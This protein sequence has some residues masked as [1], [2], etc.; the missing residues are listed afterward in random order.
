MTA[1][2]LSAV[3]LPETEVGAVFGIGRQDLYVR[4]SIGDCVSKTS[5]LRNAGK[6]GVWDAGEIFT[7]HARTSWLQDGP[8]R[9]DLVLK[10]MNSNF[11]LPDTLVGEGRVCILEHWSTDD[12]PHVLSLSLSRPG[13]GEYGT[14][15]LGITLKSKRANRCQLQVAEAARQER[16]VILSALKRSVK[17]ATLSWQQA[18]RAVESGTDPA[19]R[20]DLRYNAARC[21]REVNRTKNRLLAAKALSMTAYVERVQRRMDRSELLRNMQARREAED[22]AAIAA[23]DDATANAVALRTLSYLRNLREYCH[24]KVTIEIDPQA[25][26]GIVWGDVDSEELNSLANGQS[27]FESDASEIGKANKAIFPTMRGPSA[28]RSDITTLTDQHRDDLPRGK[29]ALELKLKSV[30]SELAAISGHS[31]MRSRLAAAEAGPDLRVTAVLP[32]SQSAAQGVRVG[33]RAV[34]LDDVV[35]KARHQLE[36]EILR[37]K[38]RLENGA[39]TERSFMHLSFT[40]RVTFRTERHRLRTLRQRILCEQKERA[41]SDFAKSMRKKRIT[42]KLG[43]KPLG[44]TWTQATLSP[45]DSAPSDVLEV[46]HSRIFLYVSPQVVNVDPNSTASM[47]KVRGGWILTHLGGV[48][49]SKE[50][51]F[52]ETLSNLRATSANQVDIDFLAPRGVDKR[53]IM[54]DAQE[55]FGVTKWSN[56]N[57]VLEIA[58]GS[59]AARLR[60]CIGWVLLSLNGEQMN[61]ASKSAAPSALAALRREAK[62]RRGIPNKCPAVFNA[63]SDEIKHV[64]LDQ[65]QTLLGIKWRVVQEDD[66][67]GALLVV[68]DAADAIVAR[69]GWK[70]LKARSEISDLIPRTSAALNSFVNAARKKGNVVELIFD[71]FD[72]DPDLKEAGRRE[73]QVTRIDTMINPTDLPFLP[74]VEP[75]LY[76]HIVR[77]VDL[78]SF[79]RPPFVRIF[80]CGKEIGRSRSG[81]LD[82]AGQPHWKRGTESFLLPMPAENNSS[83]QKSES[84]VEKELS[85]NNVGDN[86]DIELL[87]EIWTARSTPFA[88]FC[89][90]QVLLEGSDLIRQCYRTKDDVRVKRPVAFKLMPKKKRNHDEKGSSA[91]SKLFIS[92]APQNKSEGSLKLMLYLLHPHDSQLGRPPLASR[93][94][95]DQEF[96]QETLSMATATLT[97]GSVEEEVSSILLRIDRSPT[98]CRDALVRLATLAVSGQE[99]VAPVFVARGAAPLLVRLLSHTKSTADRLDAATACRGLMQHGSVA[100]RNALIAAGVV[101]PLLRLALCKDTSLFDAAAEALAALALAIDTGNSSKEDQLLLASSE[102]LANE[103][104]GINTETL[105]ANYASLKQFLESPEE[106]DASESNR[107][108]V[109]EILRANYWTDFVQLIRHGSNRVKADSARILASIAGTTFG[110]EKLEEEAKSSVDKVHTKAGEEVI[111]ALLNVADS[112]VKNA[113]GVKTDCLRSLCRLLLRPDI[114]GYADRRNKIE[115]AEARRIIGELIFHFSSVIA[116]VQEA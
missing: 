71:A 103:D 101:P 42:F 87:L 104:D 90:G 38:A 105:S 51:E 19:K 12:Q 109:E 39:A 113:T 88:P 43:E 35:L 73:Q 21:K 85:P 95:K 116:C 27:G 94:D 34:A 4:A 57:A 16:Q 49:I 74:V 59:Q 83:F 7:L 32:E 41:E 47:H 86:N 114:H 31:R 102:I 9:E 44:I 56:A 65:T 30:E 2:E 96:S 67:D 25:A 76:L 13:K 68:S 91:T 37:R 112:G 106:D 29:R 3:G 18:E 48:P 72:E 70:L 8:R 82:S 23:R 63:A 98:D 45:G 46:R 84:K 33:W 92:K 26:L 99:H 54:F 40:R 52:T 5:I 11:P 62:S 17:L 15:S 115:R 78:V 89:H 24:V 36:E 79:G 75:S 80:W 64:Q 77:G 1:T 20:A 81:D 107:E 61:T 66:E 108:L 22:L 97:R 55:E 69:S 58:P 53:L 28:Q 111:L 6:S 10:V 100:Q 50:N 14:I 110:V 60:V 93:K